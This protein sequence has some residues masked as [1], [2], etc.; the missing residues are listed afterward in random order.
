MRLVEQILTQNSCY[1]AGDTITPAGVMVHST[2]ANNPRVSRYVPGNKEIGIN[3][4]GNHWNQS[5]SQWR[6]K[7]GKKL[8]VCVHAFVGRFADGKVGIVQTLPWNIRGWHAGNNKGNDSYIGFEICEDGLEDSAYFNEVYQAAVELTAYLCQRYDLD[9]L[10]DGV[11]ICHSEGHKRGV[12]S[13]HADVMHWFPRHGKSMDNF[14]A[15]VSAKMKEGTSE[16][17]Y[18]QWKEYMKLYEAEKAKEPASAW[19]KPHI[20][21]AIDLGVMSE[22]GDGIERPKSYVTR[23]ELAVVA[24]KLA[25]KE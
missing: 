2:G 14:R 4:G 1:Q 9:P 23:Q 11:V 16:M 20:Q 3:T 10:E 24:A 18:E 19:A 13:N 22:A 15:D 17:S 12:A 7:Y 5:N 25:E 6:K 21:N 8:D